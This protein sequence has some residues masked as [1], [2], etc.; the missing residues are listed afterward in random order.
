MMA[1]VR[2]AHSFSQMTSITVWSLMICGSMSLLV[3]TCAI[4]RVCGQEPSALVIV[5]EKMHS[6]VTNF[7]VL[8]LK[9]SCVV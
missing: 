9:Y 7:H 8:L 5:P 4:L 6:L 3:P 1:V 2:Q